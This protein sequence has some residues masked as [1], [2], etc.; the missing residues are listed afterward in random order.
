MGCPMTMGL[1]GLDRGVDVNGCLEPII[2]GLAGLE[3]G[4][5]VIGDILIPVGRVRWF[6]WVTILSLA[7][8]LL[9]L[10]R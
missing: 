4:V 6:L 1:A 9:L 10:V 2:M 7:G 5:K 3:I 8:L